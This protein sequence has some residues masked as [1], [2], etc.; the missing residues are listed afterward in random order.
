MHRKDYFSFAEKV[1]WKFSRNCLTDR[2]YSYLS[3]KRWDS[4]SPNI[5]NPKSFNEKIRYL[6]ERKTIKSNT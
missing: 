5:C 4:I 6:S 2:Y 1:F 3:L